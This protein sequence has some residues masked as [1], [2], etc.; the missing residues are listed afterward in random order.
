MLLLLPRTWHAPHV[1]Q[2]QTLD[3]SCAV[4]EWIM[5]LDAQPVL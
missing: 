2:V 4:G 3:V 5:Q 1:H